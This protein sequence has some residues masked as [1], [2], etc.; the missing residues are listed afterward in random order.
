M[1]SFRDEKSKKLLESIQI[2]NVT[3]SGDTRFDRVTQILE[4]DNDNDIIRYFKQDQ[5]CLGGG[6]HLAGRRDNSCSIYQY[7]QSTHQMDY[8]PP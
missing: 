2:K 1:F 8:C 7:F 3:V 6:K 5:I 4:R